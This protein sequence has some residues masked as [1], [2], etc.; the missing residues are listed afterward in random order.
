MALRPGLAA[1]IQPVKS[2]RISL[3]SV[4]SSTSTNPVVCAGSVGGLETGK[5]GDRIADRRGQGR[6]GQH[7]TGP[8]TGNE[9]QDA[10]H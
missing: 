5:D 7:D 10:S 8:K 6:S 4:I 1:N 3:R 9:W 2:R